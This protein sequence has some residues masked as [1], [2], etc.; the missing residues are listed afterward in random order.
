MAFASVGTGGTTA[1]TAN[2]QATSSHTV[3]TNNL[4]AGRLG[5]LIISVDNS[6][7]ADGDQTAVTSMTDSAGN[8]WTKAVEYQAGGGA[9]QGGAVCSIWY[10]LAT[11]TLNAGGTISWSFTANTSRRDESCSTLWIYTVGAGVTV[12]VEATNGVAT[13]A[14]DAPSLNATTSNIACLR[15]RGCGC[16]LNNA[17]QMTATDGTWTLFTNTRSANVA[18]AVAVYGE[19]KISTGTGDASN[20]TLP[21]TCDHGSAYVAFRE[22][23]GTQTLT[24]SLYSDA[25]TFFAPTVTPGAVAL[26]PSLYSDADT[27][28]APTALSTYPLTPSLFTN[29]N[30]IGAQDSSTALL[31]HMNG[32]DASTTFI[33][34]TGLTV[35]TVD[36]AQI[37]TA[38]SVFGGASGLFGGG[39]SDKVHVP[40]ARFGLGTQ[41][42][43][44][45]ARVRTAGSATWQCIASLRGFNNAITSNIFLGFNSGTN[46]PVFHTDGANK[47]IGSALSANTWYHIALIRSGRDFKLFVDGA[48]VG[49]TFTDART[50][51]TPEVVQFGG[52]TTYTLIGWLDE[53]RISIGTDRGW[54]S[55]FTPPASA[56][57]AATVTPG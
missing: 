49:S 28:F 31:M 55:G 44:I 29:N 21:A 57:P 39:T 13:T 40:G 16:E 11:N 2:N 10:C 12:S 37:D 50:F 4:T 43:V 53:A 35:T 42:F 19:W 34:E 26:T 5:V 18:T 54:A 8:T 1:N 41:D 3:A 25:D 47:I 17:T 46:E 32:S 38:Q 36:Q 27:F 33:E 51:T 9:N 15:V 48:Q 56:Y 7:T 20:P 6:A 14:A 45:E 23:A 52:E 30:V 24:P 22:N